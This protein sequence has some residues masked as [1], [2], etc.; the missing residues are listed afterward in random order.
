MQM[1][2][3]YRVSPSGGGASISDG[4]VAVITFGLDV[5]VG[6]GGYEVNMLM[7]SFVASVFAQAM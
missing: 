2:G 1:F 4:F 3:V 5:D 6:R 7:F